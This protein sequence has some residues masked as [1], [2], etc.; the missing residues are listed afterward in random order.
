MWEHVTF[1]ENGRTVFKA[2]YWPFVAVS[3]LLLLLTSGTITT[4]IKNNLD[5]VISICQATDQTSA[6][7]FL[8]HV[9]ENVAYFTLFD[10]S[11]GMFSLAIALLVAGPYEVGANRFFLEHTYGQTAPFSRVSVG[12]TRNYGN[13]VLTQFLSRLYVLLWTLLLIIPGIVRS[14]GY[15]AV[16]FILAENPDLDHNQVLK[17]SLE[18]TNGFK[19]S[20]FYM[21]LSFLG[22]M[23]LSA[24]TFDLVGIFYAYPY[25]YAVNAEMY[26]FLREEALKNGVASPDELP[27]TMPMGFL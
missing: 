11:A 21:H 1:K 5:T 25:L 18:M 7:N 6:L 23:I 17:L 14:Y 27:G 13:V 22:W 15:F 19:A 24:L 4:Q 20:I 12:F 16:P 26:R 8:Y 3:V 2:H 10:I 9:Q